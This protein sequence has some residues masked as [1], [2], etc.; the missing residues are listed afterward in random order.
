MNWKVKKGIW[1]GLKQ[2]L[3]RS[4]LVSLRKMENS[5]NPWTISLDLKD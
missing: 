3:F 2:P 4:G 5:Y 1:N